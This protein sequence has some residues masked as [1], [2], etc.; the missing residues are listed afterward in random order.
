MLR[1][2]TISLALGL[3]ITA[4]LTSSSVLLSRL[5]PYRDLPMMP[6]PFF[7]YA[8]SPGIAAADIIDSSRTWVM[9]LVFWIANALFY[10][11]GVLVLHAL[12][13]MLWQGSSA[14]FESASAFTAKRILR[15]DGKFV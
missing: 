7:I 9:E 2:V 10:A 12:F 3:G 4:A 13:C 6:K 1:R 11:T 8:L 15:Y 5:M 14:I